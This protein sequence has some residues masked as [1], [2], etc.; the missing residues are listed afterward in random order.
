MFVPISKLHALK[1]LIKTQI[2][3]FIAR[4][5]YNGHYSVEMQN[6][7]SELNALIDECYAQFV[8]TLQIEANED[9]PGFTI[10]CK[11]CGEEIRFTLGL[12]VQGKLPN[13][14]Q[15]RIE[16]VEHALEKVTRSDG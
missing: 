14:K 15:K 10:P 11:N 7:K 6:C 16:E 4:D 8:D 5:V 3:K 2:G 13:D 12:F 1:S 9:N